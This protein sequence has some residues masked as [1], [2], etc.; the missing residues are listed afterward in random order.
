M[1]YL[2][3]FLALSFVLAVVWILYRIYLRLQD[4]MPGLRG[5]KKSI[6]VIERVGLG[7]KCSLLLVEVDEHRLLLGSTPH[8]VSLLS[9]IEDAEG[10]T[11]PRIRLVRPK[12]PVK[13]FPGREGALS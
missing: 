13:P 12:A 10:E 3:S 8:Q 7:E 4:R 9:Q 6:H 11:A 5:P 2:K 1:L